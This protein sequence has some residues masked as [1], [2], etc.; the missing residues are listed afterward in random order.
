MKRMVSLP[1]IQAAAARISDV[2]YHSP[3]PYSLSL[4]RLCGCD[5]YCK[6][7][8][9]Q[10]T[11]SFKERGAR[12]KLLQLSAAEGENGVVAASA[13]SH[14]PGLCHQRELAGLTGKAVMPSTDTN[15]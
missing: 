9:L 6:L 3:C 14:S 2:I 5:I 8:H 10:M 12:N 11:G 15:L 7:D 4:S 13:G 1:D